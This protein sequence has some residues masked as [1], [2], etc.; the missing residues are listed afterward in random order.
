MI[1]F[2]FSGFP[3]S[4]FWFVFFWVF[5]CRNF[6]FCFPNAGFEI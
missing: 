6:R 3:F 1:S 2:V 4:G 5:V